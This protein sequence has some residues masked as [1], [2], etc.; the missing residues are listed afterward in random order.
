MK[1]LGR[2]EEGGK[3]K[4]KVEGKNGKRRRENEKN[5]RKKKGRGRCPLS[6]FEQGLR[7]WHITIFVLNSFRQYLGL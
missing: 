6:D 4:G 5:E 3:E 2:S 7:L 1:L